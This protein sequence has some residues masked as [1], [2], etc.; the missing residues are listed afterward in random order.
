[1]CKRFTGRK[2]QQGIKKEGAVAGRWPAQPGSWSDTCEKQKGSIGR[3]SDHS[4]ILKRLPK[5]N[6]KSL[7][8]GCT[9]EEFP[10]RQDG[11][12][13]VTLP[14]PAL[15]G[16]SWGWEEHCSRHECCGRFG[17]V[18]AGGCPANVPC[19]GTLERVSEQWFSWP[20]H[21]D[22]RVFVGTENTSS[23]F[24]HFITFWKL[25]LFGQC[26]STSQSVYRH[27]I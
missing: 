23:F 22:K 27:R 14:V 18:A 10:I 7:S 15:P 21:G 25:L 8:K 24:S 13:L 2:C 9:L 11:L 26:D 19:L 16:R 3:V 17:D 1:M 5:A 12:Q 20:L 6:W 4:A